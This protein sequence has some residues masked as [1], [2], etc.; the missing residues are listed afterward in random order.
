MRE[1]SKDLNHKLS[2]NDVRKLDEY[3]TA[4]RDIEL[5]IERAANL[6][7][8]QTPDYPVPKGVPGEYEEHI[9]LMCDLIVLAFQADVTRVATFVLANEGSNKPYPFIKV[10]EGHHDLS[11][12]GGKAEKKEKIRT[13]HSL[14]GL[15]N[16]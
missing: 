5:R 11:H 3:F 7:P 9:R 16:I 14:H 13:H 10:S 8:I 1:D 15:I 12:H 4:I 6:P 2:V